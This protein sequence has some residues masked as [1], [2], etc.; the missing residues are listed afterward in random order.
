MTLASRLQHVGAIAVIGVVVIACAPTGPV[1]PAPTA[2]VKAVLPGI[3]ATETPVAFSGPTPAATPNARAQVNL[4]SVPPTT[5]LPV[6][7]PNVPTI[8]ATPQV[9]APT[10]TARG[11]EE[12]V[13]GPDAASEITLIAVQFES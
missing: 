1:E 10:S 4:T 7:T 5:T 11:S 6:P 2:S 8:A 12:Q 3:R 13:R 9:V